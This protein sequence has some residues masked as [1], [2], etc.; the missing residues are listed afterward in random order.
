M[1]FIHA[2]AILACSLLASC[3]STTT[4]HPDGTRTVVRRLMPEAI[5]A[6]QVHYIVNPQ[7]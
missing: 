5:E 2:L 1:K 3:E 4:Y 7:K 6:I